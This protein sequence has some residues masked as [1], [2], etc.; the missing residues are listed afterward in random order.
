MIK[1]TLHQGHIT[2]LNIYALN[3]GTSKYV[4]Q[5]LT[6]LKG[7]IEKKHSHSRD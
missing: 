4:K 3:Q 2:F 6:E 5:L 1:G 7:E